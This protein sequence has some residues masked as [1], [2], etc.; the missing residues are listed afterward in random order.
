MT[1]RT[2]GSGLPPG[3]KL[4]C[5]LFCRLLHRSIAW[6]FTYTQSR[7]NLFGL[8]SLQKVLEV[9]VFREDIVQ[10]LVR[11]IVRGCLNESGVLIDLG[12]VDLIPANGRTDVA[13]L[14]D[15]SSGILLPY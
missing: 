15:L 1:A 6:V 2:E 13:D 8:W 5:R 12:C 9:T 11:N 14:V 3:D 4:L 10:R 7:S